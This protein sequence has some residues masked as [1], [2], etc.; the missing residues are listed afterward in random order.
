MP[1][2]LKTFPI[3]SKSLKPNLV[4]HLAKKKA[5]PVV[6]FRKHKIN[7]LAYVIG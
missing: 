5:Q 4:P 3:L 6:D 1:A 7:F 2:V